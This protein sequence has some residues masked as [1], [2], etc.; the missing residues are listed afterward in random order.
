M[1]V[2]VRPESDKSPVAVRLAA[3][4]GIAVGASRPKP[5]SASGMSRSEPLQLTNTTLPDASEAEQDHPA[6]H[7]S[8]TTAAAE[9]LCWW[10][11]SPRFFDVGVKR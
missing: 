6:R 10:W 8:E 7:Q 3:K 1:S 11:D 2:I 9:W 5:V 4:L